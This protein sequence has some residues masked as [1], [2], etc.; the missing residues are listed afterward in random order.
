MIDEGKFGTGCT[1]S[2]GLVEK[3][4]GTRCH[5]PPG[6]RA[7]ACRGGGSGGRPGAPGWPSNAGPRS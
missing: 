7:R 6:V 5:R 2:M 4:A 3:V 1:A